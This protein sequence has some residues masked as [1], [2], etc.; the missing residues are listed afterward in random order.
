MISSASE[1]TS[2]QC[3]VMHFKRD[4]DTSKSN[5][6]FIARTLPS[7]FYDCCWLTDCIC[8]LWIRSWKGHAPHVQLLT[9]DTTTDRTVSYKQSRACVVNNYVWISYV[10][11]QYGKNDRGRFHAFLVSNNV[12]NI[13]MIFIF[14]IS[15]TSICLCCVMSYTCDEEGFNA[16]WKCVSLVPL[17]VILFDW[18]LLI[19]TVF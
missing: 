3:N 8:N 2:Q 6:V 12:H 10:M 13:K 19:L 16:S 4:W 17:T 5:I 7:I 11:L 1:R 9:Y 14:T 18:N 15:L